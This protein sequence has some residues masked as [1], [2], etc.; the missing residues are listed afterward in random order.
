[1]H[2]EVGIY[3]L[4]TVQEEIG[5]RGAQT[6]A[7]NLDP[8]TG[9]AIDMGVA[10]DYPRAQPS[11][12][13]ELLLG[14]GPGLSQGPNTNPVVLRLMQTAAEEAGVPIQL[15]ATGSTSPT[16]ARLLPVTRGGVAT[17][18]V[19]VPLR[20]MHTPSE[21]MSLSDVE[22]TIKLVA[23]YC[24]KLTPELELRPW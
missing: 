9:L 2:P 19:S 13:G 15:Q 3:V 12:Q 21:V 6:A 23:A 16:D 7:F 18:V 11:D 20:Y 4:G 1:V 24:R 17:G 10:T 5:S 14:R 8:H 22:S